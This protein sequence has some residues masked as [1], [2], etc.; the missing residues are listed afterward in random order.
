M[1]SALKSAKKLLMYFFSNDNIK[2]Y[3]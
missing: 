2:A 1:D 3:K